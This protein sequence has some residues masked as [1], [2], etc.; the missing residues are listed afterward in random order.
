MLTNELDREHAAGQRDGFAR[1]EAE[2]RIEHFAWA[3]PKI[4]ARTKGEDQ[5]LRD[6]LDMIRARQPNVVIQTSPH[7]FPFTEDWLRAV[8]SMT[9][10]PLLIAWEGDA[11]GRWTK[12]VPRETRAWW[13]LADMVFTTAFGKQRELIEHYGATDVRF[14][15]YTYDHVRYAE[16]EANEPPIRGDYSDVAVIGN[17]WGNR[18]VS[19]LPGA[20][21]RIALV[22]GLQ[23]DPGI[24]LAIYGLNWEG[25]GVRGPIHIDD[26][27]AVSRQALVTVSWDHFPKYEEFYSDRLTIQLLA[28]RAHVTGL[29][30]KSEWLPG[31][32]RGLFLEPS[33]DAVI[34]RVRELLARPQEEV[35]ELG[36]E[37][38]RWVR[39][40]LSDRE[41]AR[42]LLSAVDPR[43]REDLPEDPW[44]RLPT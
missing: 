42:Y 18:F 21:Q 24:P 34:R 15:P 26:Q 20:R 9:P 36:L 22:R 10:R 38:H 33:T 4:L 1:L 39:H 6:V 27:A 11:F 44:A 35:L 19:R 7:G 12:P 29:H 32:E 13:N 28:G 23:K 37:A 30:P 31:P 16:E 40:R 5:T 25:R 43:L 17:R 14:V 8:L 2:G 3:A 41:L